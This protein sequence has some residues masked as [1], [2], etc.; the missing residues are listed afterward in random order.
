M[1]FRVA[2]SNAMRGEL[3]YGAFQECEK[4]RKAASSK[5]FVLIRDI[6]GVGK[7]LVELR[8]TGQPGAAVPTCVV[9]LARWG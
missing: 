7:K 6:D 5:E 3:R 9:V 4:R 2:R 1:G 8:S